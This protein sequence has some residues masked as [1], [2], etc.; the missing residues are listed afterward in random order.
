MTKLEELRNALAAHTDAVNTLLARIAD[1]APG[2][3][4]A[5]TA[6][7]RTLTER[8]QAASAQFDPAPPVTPPADPPADT[9][10]A[11]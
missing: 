3:L 4:T 9:P 2:D 11:E 10:P 6:E 8:L 7:L 5:A 1:N